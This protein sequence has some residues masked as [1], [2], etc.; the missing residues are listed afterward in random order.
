MH[1]KLYIFSCMVLSIALSACSAYV[2]ARREAGFINP[3]GQS[4]PQRVA[5]C[6][7]PIFHDDEELLDLAK[8]TCKKGN[9]LYEDT[10]YFNCTFFYPNTAFYK[11]E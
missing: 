4:T 7:N 3:I 11:C 10:M 9:V 5:I 8:N 1:K 6:Y 2:D